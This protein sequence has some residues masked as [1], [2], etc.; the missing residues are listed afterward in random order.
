MSK[1][2]FVSCEAFPEDEYTKELVYLCL[3]GKYRVL[4]A[5]KPAKTGGLFWSVV[6]LGVT[7]N[8]KKKFYDAFMQDSNFMEKD[9]KSFL[10]ARGWE[11]RSVFQNHAS[12]S[13]RY[14]DPA[15]RSMD[16]L[17]IQDELPF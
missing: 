2:E 6:S 1:I 3:E 9:I 16:E 15:P 17:P 13:A 12:D 7:K 8:G 4:Y 10:E 14:A 5:R 11:N